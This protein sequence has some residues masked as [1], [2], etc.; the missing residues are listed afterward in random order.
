MRIGTGRAVSAS[1][2]RRVRRRRSDPCRRQVERG[3]GRRATRMGTVEP[4]HGTARH[5]TARLGAAWGGAAGRHGSARL[6]SA[7][8]GAARLG[9]AR[10]GSDGGRTLA[11]HG[12]GLSWRGEGWGPDSDEVRLYA[13]PETGR[14]GRKLLVERAGRA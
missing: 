12:L 7:R 8:H 3:G 10:L 6:G 1:S 2:S 9:L 13:V 5:G 4:V 11:P 14:A